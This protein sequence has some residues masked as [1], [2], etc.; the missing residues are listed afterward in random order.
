[1]KVVGPETSPSSPGWKVG[2]FDLAYLVERLDLIE[3]ATGHSAVC[4][5]EFLRMDSS[6]KFVITAIS[7]HRTSVRA[8]W[9][10]A[11]AVG[12]KLTRRLPHVSAV[13]P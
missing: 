1:V 6:I 7:G 5:F 10:I 2:N 4:F 11:G 8:R 12:P 3:S 9:T 13:R